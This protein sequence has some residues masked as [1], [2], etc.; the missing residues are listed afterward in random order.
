MRIGLKLTAAFLAIASLVGAV[1]YIAADADREVANQME[2]LSRSAVVKADTTEMLDALY[3]AQLAAHAL[4]AADRRELG[5]DGNGNLTKQELRDRI[6][7]HLRSFEESLERQQLAVQG[8]ILRDAG[9]ELNGPS[10]DEA[11]LL[12]QSLEHIEQRFIAHRRL[13]KE[14]LSRVEETPGKAESLLENDL[15]RSF[16]DELLPS[17]SAYRQQAEVDFTRG[18]RGTQRAMAVAD[19]RRSV[20]TVAAAAAAV[21]LGL[22]T[23]RWIGSRLGV[24]ERA[25]LEIG[26]GR[27]QT[28]VPVRSRDEIGALAA[29]LN[30]MAADLNERT[31]SRDHLDNIIRSMREMVIVADPDLQIRRVNPAACDE[32]R[33]DAAELEGLP[34]AGL[35]EAE[36]F[37][38]GTTL[39]DWFADGRQCS[40]KPKAGERLPVHCSVAQLKD[41]SGRLEGVVLVALNISRQKEAESRLMASLA[42]K[43]LLLKEVHHRVKNN[44][45]VISSLLNLQTQALRDPEAIRLFQESQSR[46]RSMALI[47]EHLYRSD[48]LARIEF[49]TYAKELVT[50][51][52]H[53]LGGSAGRIRIDM[54]MEAVSLPLDLAVPCGM[55]L[56]ELVSNAIE[57]AFPGDR[58][59]TVRVAFGRDRRGYRLEVADDG[60]GMAKEPAGATATS[61]GMKVVQALARQLHGDLQVLHDGGTAFVL[62]FRGPQGDPAAD[63][64]AVPLPCS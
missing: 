40:M 63:P 18:I 29:S 32:L 15:S 58:A 6:E 47:H 11:A 26:R 2:R 37:G 31:V 45:Q 42:E 56:H 13:I 14:F 34:L 41:E 60:V 44:L 38:A 17:L 7:V 62:C 49:Q 35:F 8:P 23:S 24:L 54:E 53:G 36:D 20:M 28:R 50:H 16:Q 21:L 59:G 48:D 57:H 43:D 4:V 33:F 46:I 30:G 22:A 64:R 10:E 52:R 3:A 55:I 12:L 27:L 5:T 25:A 61:L 9:Q 51:L 19:G 1:G 39:L